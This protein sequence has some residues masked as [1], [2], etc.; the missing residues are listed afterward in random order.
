MSQFPVALDEHLAPRYKVQREA[1]RGGVATVYLA[2]DLSSGRDVAIKVLRPELA[3]SLSTTRFLREIR[4]ARN[5][6]HPHILPVVDAGEAGG[7][8]YAVLPFVHGG[9]L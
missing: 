7:F 3:N 1:G 4:L 2:R 5:L 9:T 6:Q 8:L